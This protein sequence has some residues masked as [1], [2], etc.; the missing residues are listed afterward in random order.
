M[1]KSDSVFPKGG[2]PVPVLVKLPEDEGYGSEA[3]GSLLLKE[4]LEFSE[5]YG[6]SKHVRPTGGAGD[7]CYC[8]STSNADLSCV[9]RFR[10]LLLLSP[11][12]TVCFAVLI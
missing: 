5:V 12:V 11:L 6:F 10:L 2:R 1:I 9:C 8:R 4:K 3:E 7:V